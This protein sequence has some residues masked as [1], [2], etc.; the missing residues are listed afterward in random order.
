MKEFFS[1][2]KF[3]WPYIK[4]QKK[5]LIV[6]LISDLVIALISIVAPIL[7]AKII[8][9]LTNNEFTQL[10]VVAATI[11]GIEILRNI[12][13]YVSSYNL[14]KVYR[15]SFIRL[16]TELGRETLK[17]EN[18][19]IDA[20]SSGVFIQRLSSDTSRIA[21]IFEILIRHLSEIIAEIGIFAAI[22]I[23]NKLVFIYVVFTVII[24]FLINKR[25]TNLYTKK[26]KEMR[27]KQEKVTGFVGELVR[28]IRDIKMLNAEDSFIEELNLR[29][30]EHNNDK[31][32]MGN[33]RRKYNLLSGSFS[34]LFD[35]LLIVL[36]VYLIINNKIL[37]AN[38]LIIYNYS[39]R[40][41]SIIYAI[42]S[43]MEQIKDYNLSCTRVFAILKSDEFKKEKFGTVHLEKVNGDFEFKNVTF[44]YDDNKVLDNLSFKIN[45][46]E[47]VAFVGKSGVGKS[48]IFNLLCKMYEIESGKILIDGYD[49]NTLDKD[50]IRGNITIISQQPYIFNMSVRENLRLVKKDLTEEEMVEACKLACLH[51][52][53]LSLPDGYDTVIGEGGVNLS[54]GQRQRMAIA[55][56]LVQKTEIILFDEATS[57][58]DNETQNSIQKAID[59]MKNEYTILIIAHRLSTIINSDRIILIDDGKI[60]GE[61]T[62]QEL[63]QSSQFYRDLY[64]SELENNEKA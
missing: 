10:I 6:Y 14:Q 29:I 39:S 5:N 33:I 23:V 35:L 38:A 51:D 21:D 28:G 44:S 18:K 7:S 2:L 17:I 56:A 43:L 47:T 58:L 48:T 9:N 31:Y 42:N 61:G 3:T 52:F 45:A 8:I 16:Q 46:N 4:K 20:N 24:L 27:K 37:V 32:E 41:G 49:I 30:T 53:I 60:V 64:N 15:E 59:N 55:R 11:F 34:D 54:G 1:N 13:Y 26:D 19:S 40:V 50:T 22:F 57:A 12:A 62:H 25:Q 63:M 36:L